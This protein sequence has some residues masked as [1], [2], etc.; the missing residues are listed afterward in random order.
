MDYTAPAANNI[1]IILIVFYVI[2]TSLISALQK[3][4][5][6]MTKGKH[7]FLRFTHFSIL[8]MRLLNHCI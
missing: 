4:I 1:F 7:H 5:N 2:N 6:N 3:D 8:R